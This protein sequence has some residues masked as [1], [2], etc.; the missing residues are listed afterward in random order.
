MKNKSPKTVGAKKG[1]PNAYVAPK[2]AAPPSIPV[3]AQT[4]KLV[5]MKNKSDD[6]TDAPKIELAVVFRLTY[7]PIIE[8]SIKD[9]ELEKNI[10][11][12]LDNFVKKNI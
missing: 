7:K 4:P 9:S 1:I 10:N 3:A 6:R 2:P 5:I 8:V 12:F 11:Y